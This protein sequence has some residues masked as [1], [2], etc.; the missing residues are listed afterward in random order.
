[1]A[2]VP[3]QAHLNFEPVGLADSESRRIYRKIHTSD[4][5]WNTQDLLPAGA[6]IVPVICASNQTHWPNFSGDQHAWPLYLMIG[7]VQKNIHWTPET[8]AWICVGLI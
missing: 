3:F 2:H 6:T 4:W 8:H 1:L 5:W 7:N